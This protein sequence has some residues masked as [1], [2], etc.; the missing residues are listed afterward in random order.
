[1]EELLRSDSDEINKLTLDRAYTAAE[2]ITNE[3]CDKGRENS[4]DLKR[5]LLQERIFKEI[6]TKL[7][8]GITS[9]G[10]GILSMSVLPD[11]SNRFEI[12]HLPD[13]DEVEKEFII[14]FFYAA[15]MNLQQYYLEPELV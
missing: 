14:M 1:L 9:L 4:D 12:D 8:G 3:L 5:R 15:T 13:F 11:L 7:S 2:S 6:I 10:A